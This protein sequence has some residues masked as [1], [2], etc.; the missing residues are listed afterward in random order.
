MTFGAQE[1]S[2]VAANFS[3]D[4]RIYGG[5]SHGACTGQIY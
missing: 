5:L 1:N 3:K 2:F 4:L